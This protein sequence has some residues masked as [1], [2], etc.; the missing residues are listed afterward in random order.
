MWSVHRLHSIWESEQLRW[1]KIF[2]GMTCSAASFILAAVVFQ[3]GISLP[4]WEICVALRCL[5][6]TGLHTYHYQVA[7]ISYATGTYLSLQ[8]YLEIRLEIPTI[9]ARKNSRNTE[10][11]IRR[12]VRSLKEVWPEMGGSLSRLWSLSGLLW[13]TKEIRVL[14]LGLVCSSKSWGSTILL[15]L[16]AGQCRENDVVVST[17]SRASQARRGL[18]RSIIDGI[19][20]GEVVTTIPTIGFNVESVT[21]K[22]LNFN[23]WVNTHP[24]YEKHAQPGY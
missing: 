12:P 9:R 8:S 15:R 17:E 20:I 2:D 13:S 14:I 16:S 19:Q 7:R 18:Q 11:Y 24:P 10:T 1:L 21:Y 5:L 22:N 4:T 6:G 23:V 3:Q